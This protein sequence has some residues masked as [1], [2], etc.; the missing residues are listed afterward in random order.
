MKRLILSAATLL[1]GVSTS[2]GQYCTGGPSSGADS[3]I[4]SV[5]LTGAG[6]TAINWVASCPGV[7]GLE[8]QTALSLDLEIG[9]SY[10][11][12]ID[13][14]TC[15]GPYGN[16]GT[17]WIDFDGSQTFDLG[18]EIATWSGTGGTGI[19]SYPF[20]VP[21]TAIAG[22]VRL[23]INQQEGGALPLDPCATFIWGSSTDF[24]VNLVCPL[25]TVTDVTIC[26]G[27]STT[28]SATVSDGTFPVNISGG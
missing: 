21:N 26:T 24:S 11:I 22:P 19:I 12:D 25:P 8:D 20:T 23:R 16:A 14:S 15:G 18:E 3:N 9:G 4:G 27:T 13:W 10:T 6:G 2:F 17:A 28:L 5:D 7:T 1:I